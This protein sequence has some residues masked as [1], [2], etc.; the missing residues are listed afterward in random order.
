MLWL[1][2]ML[3]WLVSVGF[4][5]LCLIALLYV[6]FVLTGWFVNYCCVFCFYTWYYCV[7]FSWDGFVGLD[8][9]WFWFEY[10]EC[11]LF[12]ILIWWLCVLVLADS[13]LIVG[14][15][16]IVSLCF[17]GLFGW[18]GFAFYLFV[19]YWYYVYALYLSCLGLLVWFESRL[20]YSCWWV[21]FLLEPDV[22]DLTC[23]VG[24]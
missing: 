15:G 9:V 19:A 6:W 18:V 8:T 4:G 20:W 7:C 13:W 14:F 22:T 1:L 10:V 5:L 3:Y 2:C 21:W 12:Y 17:R 23:R 16:L 24:L 11:C